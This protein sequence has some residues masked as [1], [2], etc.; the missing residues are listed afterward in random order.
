MT[1]SCPHFQMEDDFC[2]KIQTDCVPGRPGCVLRHNSVLAIPAR[3]RLK[4]KE[5]E[6]R[7]PHG[8]MIEY[9]DP[10]DNIQDN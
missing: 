10:C 8:W 6:K 9:C 2:M 3:Q 7:A 5:Q 4:E 1:F